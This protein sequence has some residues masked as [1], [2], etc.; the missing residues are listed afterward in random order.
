MMKNYIKMSIKWLLHVP[1]YQNHSF[2]CNTGT[3]KNPKPTKR[4]QSVNNID[5]GSHNFLDRRPYKR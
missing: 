4:I 3:D 2:S 5:I 1:K